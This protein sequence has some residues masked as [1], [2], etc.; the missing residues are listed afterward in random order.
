[1]TPKDWTRFVS[2]W[3]QDE[4]FREDVGAGRLEVLR[5]AGF[6]VDESDAPI[7]QQ[8]AAMFGESELVEAGVS[9][10]FLWSNADGPV[11]EC[12]A[13][14]T[15]ELDQDAET[16]AKNWSN[17]LAEAV[18]RK[19]GPFKSV[20]REFRALALMRG[21]ST[22]NENQ[23]SF[24]TNW[25]SV[26]AAEGYRKKLKDLFRAHDGDVAGFPGGGGGDLTHEL[27]D[28]IYADGTDEFASG[29]KPKVVYREWR[30]TYEAAKTFGEDLV[31]LIRELPHVTL[32]GG[33]S[34]LY[35]G[36]MILR[37]R[38]PRSVDYLR[39]QLLASFPADSNFNDA[40]GVVNEAINNFTPQKGPKN[41][42]RSLRWQVRLNNF[43]KVPDF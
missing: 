40:A 5:A 24:A 41:P 8:Y 13:V 30:V 10:P 31:G 6:T 27:W 11:C 7:L 9:R 35:Q 19:G 20:Q 1:V 34:N 32:S 26:K 25:N 23:F 14:F 16:G 38:V 3:M 33:R 29:N 17:K 36:G 37:E 2:R 21:R 22:V 43:A 15:G 42:H 28:L 4:D 39:F 18:K 12:I